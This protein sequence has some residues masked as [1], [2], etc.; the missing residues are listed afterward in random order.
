MEGPLLAAKLDAVLAT[1]ARDPVHV[2]DAGERLGGLGADLAAAEAL[3]TAAPLTRQAGE[4]RRADRLRAQATEHLARCEGARAES[5]A[6]DDTTAELTPRERE[7]A[8]LA[9]ARLPSKRIAAE[10]GVTRRTVD[11]LLARAYRKLG[12]SSRSDLEV[13][14]GPPEGAST[15]A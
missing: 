3:G 5:L 8:L 6:P 15:D 11:N 13:R 7:V 12:V 9:A 14:L 2:A 4:R 10:L 1:A